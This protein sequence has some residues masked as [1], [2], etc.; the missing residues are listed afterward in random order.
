LPHAWGLI[1]TRLISI[2]DKDREAFDGSETYRPVAYRAA[3]RA[4]RAD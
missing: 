3:Q 1:G 2:S 4:V